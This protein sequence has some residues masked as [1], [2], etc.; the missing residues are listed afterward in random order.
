MK[1]EIDRKLDALVVVDSTGAT[2]LLKDLLCEAVE[3]EVGPA[4][5][6]YEYIEKSSPV[7]QELR[8]YE[9]LASM[10]VFRYMIVTLPKSAYHYDW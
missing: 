10:D 5:N 8:K 1:V 6:T 4:E 7:A 2:R 9:R 3:R